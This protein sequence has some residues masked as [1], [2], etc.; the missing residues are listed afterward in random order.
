MFRV[1]SG[2]SR[3]RTLFSPNG[4]VARPTAS[5]AREALFNVLSDKVRGS[6][7]L[8]LFAGT[9]AIGIEA[10]SCG[11]KSAVFVDASKDCIGIVKKNIEK[12][13]F[14]DKSE[15]HLSDANRALKNLFE[16]R[17]NFDII[18]LDPPYDNSSEFLIEILKNVKKVMSLDGVCVV[19]RRKTDDVLNYEKHGFVEIK[20]KTYSNARLVFLNK[21][22]T[23][24]I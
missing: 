20:T 1:I 5:M 12:M 6:A 4:F 2:T 9:G 16:K 14:A 13:G 8:D 24:E 7:V 17:R 10:L 3:G 21:A 22:K 18:Y 15:V 11:A 23:E 19:E